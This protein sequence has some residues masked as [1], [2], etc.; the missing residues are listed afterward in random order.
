MATPYET[1]VAVPFEPSWNRDQLRVVGFIQEAASR[2][3]LGA[4]QLALIP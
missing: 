3:V 2:N 1:D 4:A